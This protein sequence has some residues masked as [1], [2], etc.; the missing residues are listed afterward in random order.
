MP[1]RPKSGE[2]LIGTYLSS[3]IRD[4]TWGEYT[5]H[6]IKSKNRIFYASGAMLNDLFA[7]LEQDTKIKLVFLGTKPDR[8]Y[9]LFELLKISN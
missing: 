8:E 1:W 6:F 2:E 5:V 4:G 7:L 3:K 9:K